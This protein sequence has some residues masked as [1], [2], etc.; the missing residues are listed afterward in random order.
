MRLQAQPLQLRCRPRQR[1]PRR[2]RPVR[3]HPARL[4]RRAARPGL[5]RYARA[6]AT[7]HQ[8]VSASASAVH[9]TAHAAAA[10]GTLL[11]PAAAYPPAPTA[12]PRAAGTHEVHGLSASASTIRELV[13]AGTSLPAAA[14][15]DGGASCVA[16]P[17]TDAVAYNTRHSPRKFGVRTGDVEFV[18][19]KRSA[20]TFPRMKGHVPLPADMPSGPWPSADAA[21][22]EFA[23]FCRNRNTA[24]G[25]WGIKWANAR[26]HNQHRGVQRT[27]ACHYHN[28]TPPCKWQVVLE[29]CVEGWAVWSCALEHSQHVLTQTLGESNADASMRFI[30]E[31]L[32]ANGRSMAAAGIRITDIANYIDRELRVVGADV[33]FVYKDVFDEVAASTIERALDATGF[34]ECLMERTKLQGLYHRYTTDADGCLD[35]AFF[36]M[37]GAIDMYA[38]GQRT[39][40]VLFDTKHGTNRYKLKLGL[41]T[42][43]HASGA[44]KVLAASLVANETED[45][46]RFV[47]QCFLEAFRVPP[48]VIFTDSDPAMAAALRAIMAATIH[49]LCIW[50]L[51]KNILSNVRPAFA[52]DAAKWAAFNS[53][54]WSICLCTDTSSVSR[55]D[56]EWQELLALLDASA[57]D[58]KT[59]NEARTWLATLNARR[60][61]WAARWC[62]AVL[63]LGVHSTQRAEAVHSAVAQF[64]SASM[65]LTALLDKLDSYT[66]SVD[67][68]ADTRM[69]R[70]IRAAAKSAAHP[71]IASVQSAVSPYALQLVN[72]QLQQ[73]AFYHVL[74]IGESTWSVTRVSPAAGSSTPAADASDNDVTA[75]TEAAEYGL[76]TASLTVAARSTTLTTCSCQYMTCWGLPCRHIL[77]VHT[78]L[79]L[80][81]L[82]IALFNERWRVLEPARHQQ[83]LQQLLST[84]LLERTPATT[85]A[86]MTS[87]DRY[88]LLCAEFRVLA[89]LGSTSDGAMAQVRSEIQA[90]TA[91]LRRTGGDVLDR[92]GPAAAPGRGGAARGRGGRGAGR[93]RGD[94]TAGA[95]GAHSGGE[96][97][98]SLP[99]AAPSAQGAP[100]ASRKCSAC[101]QSGHRS[102]NRACPQ[103]RA[104]GACVG[105]AAPETAAAAPAQAAA[106]PAAAAAAVA[107]AAAVAAAAGAAAVAAAVGAAAHAEAGGTGPQDG[108]AAGVGAAAASEGDALRAA[109]AEPGV[110]GN[111]QRVSSKGR[112]EQARHRS[113]WEGVTARGGRAKKPRK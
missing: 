46:F 17:D 101:G 19:I 105:E 49:L 110:V 18:I 96:A 11:L 76:F 48:A 52:G 86:S 13:V 27:L 30:P 6:G 15:Q 81:R 8:L 59:V 69:F 79:Q 1:T 88:S 89:E 68:R 95:D 32:L 107:G 12:A 47:F 58:A 55:F 7:A 60:K 111:P 4:M 84:P 21:R 108:A 9:A 50:H 51:S 80:H 64:L 44:T 43:V 102:D 45:S 70:L 113:A 90:V 98:R 73:A 39:N 35:K 5:T 20:A 34:V 106:D 23:A 53:K 99:P 75:V 16:A 42:T 57:A 85:P 61:Q 31:H 62:W 104:G 33:T 2:R 54:W 66:D 3:P 109:A 22:S 77:C 10:P 74:P 83:L 78:H 92:G 25:G 63:T 29:E 65:L 100:A 93:G 14:D 103:Y 28:H 112:P 41:L 38:I 94:G 91:R 37:A 36:V 82:E 71:L 56:A 26:A 97:I 24:G 40:V 67:V 72:V 87:T